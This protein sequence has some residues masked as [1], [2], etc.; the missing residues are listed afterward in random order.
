MANNLHMETQRVDPD[1]TVVL[2]AGKIVMG[3]DSMGLETLVVDLIRRDQKKI[4]FDLSR[5]YYIDSTGM[6]AIATC[7]TRAMR[8]GGGLRVA[9]VAERVRQL[10]KITSLDR[11]VSFYASVQAAAEGFQERETT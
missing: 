4:V 3:P 2:L 1:V 8:A 6:G 10:F 5:V 9:G 7:F 11:V